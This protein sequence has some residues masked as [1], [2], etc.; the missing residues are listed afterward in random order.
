MRM[1]EKRLGGDEVA[2]GAT[3]LV[4]DE[5]RHARREVAYRSR[6]YW[7]AMALMMSSVVLAG[8]VTWWTVRAELSP[9]LAVA[10][11]VSGALGVAIGVFL[12]DRS[13]SPGWEGDLEAT[14]ETSRAG[15]MKGVV[16]IAV[17]ILLA[18]IIAAYRV[19][20]LV[21]AGERIP[22]SV[23]ILATLLL[24]CVELAVPVGPA[25]LAAMTDRALRRA[26]ERYEV[27]SRLS[28]RLRTDPAAA[29]ALARREWEVVEVERQ[30]REAEKREQQTVCA[31]G[32]EEASPLR[33]RV[34]G[35]RESFLREWRDVLDRLLAADVT[36][37]AADAGRDRDDGAAQGRRAVALVPPDRR[38]GG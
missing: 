2:A 14:I 32:L 30:E 21:Q 12:L 17:G 27:R 18:V 15:R 6:I 10:V 25:A 11:G 5:T 28:G 16:L 33:V 13:R 37:D 29:V 35:E 9:I 8:I 3:N 1:H 36:G 31:R 19:L 7:L 34:L 24:I 38:A 4:A 22:L 23:V 26:L 20:R